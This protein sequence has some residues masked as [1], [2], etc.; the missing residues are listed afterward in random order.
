[1]LT[2]LMQDIGGH[3]LAK[4]GTLPALVS[5]AAV[6]GGQ[7]HLGD[8]FVLQFPELGSKSVTFTVTGLLRDFPT[9]YPDGQPLSFVVVNLDDLATMNSYGGINTTAGPNEYWL[10]TSV[11]QREQDA[12][13]ATLGKV[14][15]EFGAQNVLSQRQERLNEET[16][17]LNGGMRGLLWA[18]A[19]I[20]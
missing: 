4:P 8:R 17:P 16:A 9:L 14:T 2:Q 11:G 5:G 7:L 13:L 19:G 3:D 1:P 6:Q 18:S 20:A 15:T 12:L 10:S